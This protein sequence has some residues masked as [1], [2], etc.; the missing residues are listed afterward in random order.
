[1]SVF[2]NYARYYDLLYRDKDY[3]REAQFV[4][5][6]LQTYAPG[7]QS[8]LELGCGTGTH[9]ILL[10]KEGYYINGV[11]L[12]HEM[13]QKAKQRLSQ[14]SDRRLAGQLELC[15]GD[16]R[17]V[18]L[19]KQFDA[20]ISLFHVVS[21]Q[22]TIEDLRA[23]FSTVKSH[24]KTGG[25]FIFDCWYGPAV[26]TARPTVRVKRLED[27]AIQVTRIA[28]PVLY[29]N[30][31]LV[32]VNY[33]VFIRDKSSG[34][35]EEVTETHRMRYLFRSEVDLLLAE[36]D[37]KVVISREWI[38]DREPGFDTWGVYYVVRDR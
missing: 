24:L 12:S 17:E 4:N 22:S 3:A 21:Y 25:I 29:P 18:R 14:M 33:H 34:V 1:M 38:T 31:N 36:A 15:Q 9:A 10:A 7:S 28:E 6:L 16:V 23:I 2:G 32:D 35:V 13:L 37:L 8:I 19:N 20:V 26:L 11:D 27:E 30:D 5:Q